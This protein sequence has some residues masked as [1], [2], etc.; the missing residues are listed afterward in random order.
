MATAIAVTA[1]QANEF[2]YIPQFDL[3]FGS[4]F[5]GPSYSYFFP[6]LALP[7][8]DFDHGLLH[9]GRHAVV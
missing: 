3:V 2:M 9:W 8:M 5:I 7:W 1:F 4:E 6:T